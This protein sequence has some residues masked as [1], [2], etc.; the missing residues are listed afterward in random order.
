MENWGHGDHTCRIQLGG[1]GRIVF[2]EEENM[3]AEPACYS[4][5]WQG[6]KERIFRGNVNFFY[7]LK[8]HKQI[9][10]T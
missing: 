8:A 1:P 9:I 10:L 3:D 6:I 5:G 7:L 2:L 4:L